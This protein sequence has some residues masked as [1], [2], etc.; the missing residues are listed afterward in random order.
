[1]ISLADVY[2]VVAATVPLYFAMILAYT[3][4][5]WWKL[6]TPEQCAGINK[7]VAKF[8][9]PLLSFQVISENNP[10]KM[11]LKLILADFLQKLLAF[12]VLM[13]I[14]KFSSRGGLPSIITGLSLSTLPNTLILGIPLLRAM[15]GDKSATLLAQIVVLQSLIWYN[16]LLFLYELNAT[17]AA[18]ETPPSQDSGDLEAP[19][20]AQAKEGGEEAHT[21]PRKSKAM[22]IFLTVGKKLMANPNTHA[23]LLG[24]IW[25]SIQF[26]W[27]I[28]FPAIIEKSIAILSSG[29]LGMAM[30]SLGL[31]MA[32]RPS[33][34]ACGIRM[35][36]VAMAMKFMAG[37]ALMAASSAALGLR[38][39]VLRVAIVQ[40][41]LPQ[42]VV[43]FVFA[44]EYNVHPDVLSTGVIFGLLI[45]LPV[46]LVYYL[47]LAV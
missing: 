21:R 16:I 8:S 38:G 42:G 35:A 34:I 37:P 47:I 25:A 10:Y 22:L 30:F 41:A 14:E 32:S 15:Y 7:F 1:M 26:R 3:S 2:H 46:A 11:N 31:F 43:P 29:G 6:F 4:V 18:S 33:I 28:K 24:L 17:K 9:I 19:E 23:T 12:V 13:A 20:E 45:A 27:N 40:A 5:K 36:A 44:K 39:K